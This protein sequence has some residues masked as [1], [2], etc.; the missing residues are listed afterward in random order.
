MVDLQFLYCDARW[1]TAVAAASVVGFVLL[2]LMPSGTKRRG[3]KILSVT[4][5]QLQE[6]GQRIHMHVLRGKIMPFTH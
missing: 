3:K 2:I 6:M 1:P 5:A 4:S